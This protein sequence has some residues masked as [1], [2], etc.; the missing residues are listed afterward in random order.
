M[1][2]NTH[3]MRRWKNLKQVV[4][5]SGRAKGENMSLTNGGEIINEFYIPRGKK[6]TDR[7]W[8]PRSV[9]FPPRDV[10]FI[11]DRANICQCYSHMRNYMKKNYVK[12]MLPYVNNTPKIH[13]RSLGSV[14][15]IDVWLVHIIFVKLTKISSNWWNFLKIASVNTDLCLQIHIVSH[16]G[17]RCVKSSKKL[18]FKRSKY[19]SAYRFGFSVSK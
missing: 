7:G 2:T 14:N 6:F 1:L 15:F 17:I 12:L 9:N 8:R 4:Y 13:L 19:S 16:M 18:Y 10:K 11:D 5:E 3:C